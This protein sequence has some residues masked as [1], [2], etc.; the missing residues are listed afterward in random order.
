[1][2]P[3]G[4]RLAPRSRRVHLPCQRPVGAAQ[5]PPQRPGVDKFTDV[6]GTG[7]ATWDVTLTDGK[8]TYIC[9][10]HAPDDEGLVHGRHSRAARRHPGSSPEASAPARRSRFVRSAKAGKAVLTIRDRSAADNFHMTGPGVNKRRYPFQGDGDVDR[11]A[12]GRRLHVPVGRAQEAQGDDARLPAR[13]D[14][15]PGSVQNRRALR[16]GS[17]LRGRGGRA[18]ASSRRSAGEQEARRERDCRRQRKPRAGASARARA[19]SATTPPLRRVARAPRRAAAGSGRPSSLQ[20][21]PI[22]QRRPS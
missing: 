8:Y 19:R 17:N 2:T 10:A 12:E 22:L 13:R 7:E 16:E 11:D 4:R 6:P 18:G 15:E 21:L 1:V 9:D 3:R 20:P 5:L 14:P